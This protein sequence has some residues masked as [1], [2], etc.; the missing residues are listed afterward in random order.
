MYA[1]TDQQAFQATVSLP[2]FLGQKKAIVNFSYKPLEF[3]SRL[4]VAAVFATLAAAGLYL[5]WHFKYGAPQGFSTLLMVMFIFG[6]IQLLALSV[7]GEYLIR[8]FQEV[9]GRPP[10]IISQIITH[11]NTNNQPKWVR[12]AAMLN[13]PAYCQFICPACKKKENIHDRP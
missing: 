7:I 8:I 3:I 12:P 11:Q 13:V 5:Y 10:Y 9:K 2:T 6:T 4:A 1:R